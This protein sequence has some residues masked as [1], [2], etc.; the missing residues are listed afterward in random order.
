MKAKVDSHP[1]ESQTVQ[2]M[3]AEIAHRYDFLNHFLS[4]SIDRR[5]RRIAAAKIGEHIDGTHAVCL[6]LC[7]GTG[8]LALELRRRLG[9]KVVAADFCHPMLVRCANKVRAAHVEGSIR[10]I[11]ADSLKLPFADK[12]FDAATVAFG[13]RNLEDRQAGLL[14][15]Q[16][17]LKPGGVGAVLEF[18]QPVI[19]FFREAF[20]LYFHYVLP[21]LGSIISG[22]SSAYRYLPESVRRFPAQRELAEMMTSAGFIDV[23]WKNLSGGIAALHWGT[24]SSSRISH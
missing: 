21:L 15:M 7:S 3:F 6:D 11:E 20:G 12:S 24:A 4:L 19:P 16:R 1:Q 13:L 10:T 17:V 8:D 22:Q 18:S 5:W 9:A 23:S 2:R 14:E